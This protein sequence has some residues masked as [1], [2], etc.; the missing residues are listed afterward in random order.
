MLFDINSIF[1]HIYNKFLF[2]KWRYMDI[3]EH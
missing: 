1:F 3:I 2:I